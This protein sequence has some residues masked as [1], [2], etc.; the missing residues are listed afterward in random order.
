MFI[1][2]LSKTKPCEPVMEEQVNEEEH[3]PP[4]LHTVEERTNILKKYSSLLI[5]CSKQ[6]ET[7][8]RET[9]HMMKERI[10]QLS[11]RSEVFV[12]PNPQTQNRQH[13]KRKMPS[14]IG[15]PTG[16]ASKVAGQKAKSLSQQTSKKHFDSIINLS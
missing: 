10:T 7:S 12:F 8:F 2:L 15:A 9:L 4:S 3:V 11:G 6:N 5:E 1:K 16:K 14:N 13:Q